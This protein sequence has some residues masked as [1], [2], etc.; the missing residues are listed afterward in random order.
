MLEKII[1]I[2]EENTLLVRIL[3]VTKH[4]RIVRRIAESRRRIAIEVVENSR[5]IVGR[6]GERLLGEPTTRV[7]GRSG[8]LL[9]QEV[10][11]R[12][13][14]RLG[15]HD[16]NVLVVFRGGADQRDT[17]DVDLLDNG[18][19]LSTRRDC[20]LERIEINDH[21]VDFR[22]LVLLHLRQILRQS[23]ASQNSSENL[24]VQ[25]LHATSQ[26]GRV[27]GEGLN[28]LARDTERLD[29]SLGSAR[30][31]ELNT[32]C[33]QG[34]YNLIQFILVVNRDQSRLNFFTISHL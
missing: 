16:D 23:A 34:T 9:L 32:I 7:E 20:I 5:I 13:V 24:R 30:R 22:Y 26:D 2:S 15:S 29:E 1:E 25:R 18:L 4:L 12:L 19:L 3:T 6:H 8:A 10:Q 11:E 27:R 14:L 28:S 17:S 21:Q 31:N 33:V